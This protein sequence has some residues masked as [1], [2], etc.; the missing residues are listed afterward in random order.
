LDPYV[1]V[2]VGDEKQKTTVKKKTLNPRWQEEF[3]FQLI[4]VNME[5]MVKFVVF[6]WHRIPEALNI[7]HSADHAFAGEV[8]L[9]LKSLMPDKTKDDWFALQGPKEAKVTGELHLMFHI[10]TTGDKPLLQPSVN[11]GH[12]SLLVHVAKGRNLQ[13]KDM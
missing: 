12:G 9:P 13:P 3:T 2:S 6:D 7:I 5:S 10:S 11:K 4:N 1:I 8:D